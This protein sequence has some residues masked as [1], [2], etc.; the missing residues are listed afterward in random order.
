LETGIFAISTAQG[1]VCMHFGHCELFAIV[2]VE[3]GKIAE[4]RS[5]TP[6]HHEPG[7]FPDWLHSLNV[8]HILAGGMGQRAQGMFEEK[9]IAVVTGVANGTPVDVVE[10]YL[11]GRLETGVNV[12][13]H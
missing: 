9:G 7:V 4:F 10:A 13:D 3:E 12:C 8:T 1:Q 2:K 11:A 6:P 5:L